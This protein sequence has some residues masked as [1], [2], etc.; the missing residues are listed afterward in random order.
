M[1][2]KLSTWI[3]DEL[4][5][6]V[7]EKSAATEENKTNSMYLFEKIDKNKTGKISLD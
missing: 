3:T 4:S 5:E 1:K 6:E 7:L 2:G